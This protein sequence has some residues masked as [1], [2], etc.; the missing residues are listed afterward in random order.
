MR[1]TLH[2]RGSQVSIKLHK[3]DALSY[4]YERGKLFSPAHSSQGDIYE[5]LLMM[6]MTI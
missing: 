4:K 6:E 1:E 3:L 5:K 2:P